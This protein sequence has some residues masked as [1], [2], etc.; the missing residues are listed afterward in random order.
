MKEGT[1]GS[2]HCM[3]R[4]ALVIVFLFSKRLR[5]GPCVG[6]NPKKWRREGVDSEKMLTWSFDGCVGMSL[7]VP[8]FLAPVSKHLSAYVSDESAEVT[9]VQTK[10]RDETKSVR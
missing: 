9:M 3:L 8:S 10:K 2:P 7:F 6:F 5:A 1:G 4:C